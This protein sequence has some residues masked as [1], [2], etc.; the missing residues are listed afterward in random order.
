M[1]VGQCLQ[2]D[3]H[4]DHKCNLYA[5]QFGKMRKQI[6]PRGDLIFPVR[7]FNKKSDLFKPFVVHAKTENVTIGVK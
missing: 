2:F 1:C 7:L 4:F 6:V 3:E 5:F